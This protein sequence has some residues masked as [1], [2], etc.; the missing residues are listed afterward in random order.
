MFTEVLIAQLT[1]ALTGTLIGAGGRRL[2]R[3]LADPEREGALER[4]CEAGIVALVQAAHGECGESELH[5]LSD[6]LSEFFGSAEIRDDLGRSLAPLL[7]G[8]EWDLEEVRE[9]FEETGYDPET[10]P[11]LDFDAAFTAFG[12]GFAAAA[13]EQ[14]A[15]RDEMRTHLLFS[16]LELQAEIRD[17]LSSLAEFLAR[18]RPGT[19]SVSADRITAETVAG[20]Q[21]IFSSPVLESTRLRSAGWEEHYL[22]TLV[23]QCEPLDL[24]PI[25]ETHPHGSRPGEAGSVR[26][27]DVFTSLEIDGVERFPSMSVEAALQHQG[28]VGKPAEDEKPVPITAL[29]ATAAVSRLVVLGRPGGGK[30]TLVNHL[31]T[32]LAKRQLG[33]EAGE[34]KLPG[35]PPDTR[36]LPVR[37]ILRR[38]ASW[39]PAEA[40]ASAGLVWDYLRHQ[41]E[42][43]DGCHGAFDGLHETLT[44]AGGV[45]FFDGLDEVHEDDARR[46]RSLVRDSIAD[47]SRPLEK[48]R[49]V[50]T[51]R[52]YAYRRDDASQ[53]ALP[54]PT[55]RSR[56]GC[57]WRCEPKKVSSRSSERHTAARSPA[58]AIRG[59]R[60][61][62]SRRCNSAGCPP[63][64]SGWAATKGLTMRDPA[65]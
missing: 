36:S 27:S 49:I 56:T 25:D 15:L 28:R 48:C 29:E 24:S 2:R 8:H 9:L 43:Q 42:H 20:T 5:H 65:T 18:A 44:R 55:R 64:L 11:C 37:V 50:V 58:W 39:L 13:V 38:F 12:G 52:E 59:R 10:L 16:Q 21:I 51:C 33:L 7:K 4:C 32:Q 14:P 22:R 35:W 61:P 34:D 31:A 6:L 62:P 54:P 60:S 19:A 1:K 41:L 53:D 47:F 23:G 30:S 57:C 26:L 17:Q 45:V 46:H 63:G 3:A 40:A